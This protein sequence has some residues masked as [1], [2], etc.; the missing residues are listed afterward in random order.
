MNLPIK[1]HYKRLAYLLLACFAGLSSQNVL[2]A[3]DWSAIEK[4]KV[5][6]FYPG[7]AS[8]DMLKT[9]DH[10]TGAKAVAKNKKSCAKCHVSKKGEF[11]IAADD[12]I[13]GKLTM[14]ETGKT[15]EP[16]P[17]EGEGYMDIQVQAAYDADNVYIKVSWPSAGT[18]FNDA[19]VAKEL[20]DRVSLQLAN[21]SLKTFANSGCYVT[22]HDDL[23][24]MPEGTEGKKLYAE[25]AMKKGKAIPEKM[26]NKYLSSGRVIDQWA[27]GFNG[28]ELVT[29]DE[30]ILQDRI[31]DTNNLTTTGSYADGEYSVTFTR[32]LTAAEQ[33]D[34]SFEAGEIV[35]ISIAIHE[36]KASS[37]FHYTSFPFALGL[38][39]KKADISAV[40]L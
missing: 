2:A 10:G 19:S 20:A 22:C 27:V 15:Y 37:R 38:D 5:T 23:H 32:S 39:A 34:I 33:G 11:D 6:I 14:S 30:Y 7:V 9:D 1:T 17:R 35:N 36:N 4:S 28:A 12:I 40:K 25:F 8:W 3:P 26:L 16:K 21:D 24:D 13:S 29:T 18:S 31:A